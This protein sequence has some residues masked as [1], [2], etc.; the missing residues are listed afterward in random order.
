MKKHQQEEYRAKKRIENDRY[1]R[2]KEE[3]AKKN[4][5]PQKSEA[6]KKEDV[7]RK[8]KH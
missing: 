2:K 7:G 5:V 4:P 8:G 1:R 3:T 6:S